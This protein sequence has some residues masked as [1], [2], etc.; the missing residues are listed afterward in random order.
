MS[1]FI[2]KSVSVFF[3]ATGL[4]WPSA[5]QFDQ[6]SEAL[7]AKIEKA[8][9]CRIQADCAVI[10]ANKCPYGCRILVN[11]KKVKA[12]SKALANAKSLCTLRCPGDKYYEKRKMDCAQGRCEWIDPRKQERAK[13]EQTKNIQAGQIV[14]QRITIIRDVVSRYKGHARRLEAKLKPIEKRMAAGVA[15]T[16]NDYRVLTELEQKYK[17]LGAAAQRKSRRK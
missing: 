2:F 1:K 13:P 15:P 7:R 6:K 3:L 17:V 8:G 16:K 4:V 10:E 5:A 14:L 12:I 9:Q 11:K